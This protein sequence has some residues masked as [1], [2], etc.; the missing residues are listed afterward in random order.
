MTHGCS[1]FALTRRRL[2][3]LDIVTAHSL[4]PGRDDVALLLQETMK[5]EGWTG[6]RMEEQR[7]ILDEQRRRKDKRQNIRSNVGRVLGVD[8][9]W[10]GQDS[11]TSDSEPDEPTDALLVSIGACLV[12][13]LIVV[14]DTSCGLRNYAGFFSEDVTTDIGFFDH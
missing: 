6:G 2:T 12:S 5:S 9:R 10:W 14:V 8:S 3:P 4:M 7:R 11:D 1:P 13:V